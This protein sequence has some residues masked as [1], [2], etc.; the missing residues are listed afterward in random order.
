VHWLSTYLS[1][2]AARHPRVRGHGRA[3]RHGASLRPPP[4]LTPPPP[5]GATSRAFAEPLLASELG[6]EA[7]RTLQVGGR[8]PAALPSVRLHGS[9]LHRPQH[10]SHRPKTSVKPQACHARGP[11]QSRPN[12]CPYCL[13]AASA[14]V[15]SWRSQLLS[16]RRRTRPPSHRPSLDRAAL[17]PP[18]LNPHPPSSHVRCPPRTCRPATCR[19][20]RCCSA[21]SALRLRGCS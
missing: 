4:S 16:L 11:R 19:W 8:A 5:Q 7:R 18:A 10:L 12:P 13:W 2:D 1:E 14:V 3:A 9:A 17:S 6:P 21:A 15:S 20:R